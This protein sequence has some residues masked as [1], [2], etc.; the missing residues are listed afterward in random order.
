VSVDFRDQ[1][2]RL[3]TP[4]S[5][6]NEKAGAGG[7][8]AASRARAAMPATPILFGHFLPGVCMPADE[9]EKV[10]DRMI[11]KHL[12]AVEKLANEAGCPFEGAHTASDFAAAEILQAAHDHKY[13]RICMAPR[14][15]HGLAAMMPS[16][17]T[18]KVLA[19][20]KVPVPVFR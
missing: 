4:K 10:I 6:A 9:H 12:G 20:A 1:R 14:T 19:Q 13:D 3:V 15:R 7:N 16:S 17:Q 18:Q 8:P 11:A 2:G 5:I